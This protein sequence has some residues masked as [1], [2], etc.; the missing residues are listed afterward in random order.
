M[1][2]LPQKHW[3]ESILIKKKNTNVSAYIAFLAFWFTQWNKAQLSIILELI[4]MKE[5][6][7]LKPEVPKNPFHKVSI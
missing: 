3:G 7:A 1:N 4:Y 5:E 2:S 6:M